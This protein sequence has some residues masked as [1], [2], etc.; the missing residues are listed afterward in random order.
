MFNDFDQAIGIRQGGIVLDVCHLRFRTD[1]DIH[2]SWRS[3]KGAFNE[4]RPSP[5]I[6]QVVD[7][8]C[9]SLRFHGDTPSRC[10]WQTGCLGA[11]SST[12]ETQRRLFDIPLPPFFTNVK[13]MSPPSSMAKRTEEQLRHS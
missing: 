13:R 1:I 10:L 12:S 4:K 2:Y 8:Q 9:D 6:A 7:R 11:S 3:C 5:A